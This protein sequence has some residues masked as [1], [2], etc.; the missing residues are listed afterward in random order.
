[1]TVLTPPRPPA[2]DGHPED[3]EALEALI[4]EARRRARRRRI[5]NGAVVV[6]IGGLG[7]AAF[8]GF[9]GRG[10]G[11]GAASAPA[12]GEP[13]PAPNSSATPLAA[14]PADSG[15]VTRIVFDP[16]AP[17]TVYVGTLGVGANSRGHVYKTTDAGQHWD[18]TEHGDPGWTR[19]DALTADPQHPRTLYAGTGVAVYKTV[20]GGQRWVG[21]NRGLLPPP[22]VIKP[23][24]VGG[25]PGWRRGEGWVTSLAVDPTNS[26]VVYAAAGGVRKSIDGGH[27]WKVVFWLKNS[28]LGG[29]TRLMI[30]PASPHTIYAIVSDG[31]VHDFTS[32]YKSADGGATWRQTG[33]RR[34][35]NRD[36]WGA[37]LAFVPKRSNALFAAIGHSAFRSNDAGRSWQS[38]TSGLPGQTVADLVLD[39][40][41]SG[42]LYAAVASKT[43]AIY[44]TTNG[45]RSWRRI[46]SAPFQVYAVAVD[47]ERPAT[48][49][50]SGAFIPPHPDQGRYRIL[51]SIDSGRTWTIAG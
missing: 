48:L 13:S 12:G 8:L 32:V 44:K 16:R 18:S 46:L 14:L 30:T 23:G 27:T 10:S 50:A 17:E 4:E 2:R 20:N 26:K 28:Y 33:L 9:G 5:R 49:F 38:I 37:S 51:R 25:T 35:S 42:T 21:W 22:P 45:G 31:S 39:P 11:T 19:V 15:L 43:G 24:Q 47:P 6:L 34:V 7:V 3:P 36:G 29:V 41:R 1:L 40:R